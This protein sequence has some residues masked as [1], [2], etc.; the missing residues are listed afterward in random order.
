M[1]YFENEFKKLL[2]KLLDGELSDVIENNHQ[3]IKSISTSFNKVLGYN[4]EDDNW[5]MFEDDESKPLAPVPFTSFASKEQIDVL[6]FGLNPMYGK[7]VMEEKRVAGS[8]WKDY[9]RFYAADGGF[10]FF[11]DSDNSYYKNVMKMM[12]GLKSDTD[13][14]LDIGVASIRKAFKSNKMSAVEGNKASAEEIF[15]DHS[16]V[17]ADLMPFHSRATSFSYSDM[18]LLEESCPTYKNYLDEMK[19]FINKSMANEGLIIGYGSSTSKTIYNMYA[20]ERILDKVEAG[21]VN[22]Y[23]LEDKWLVLF[24]HQILGFNCAMPGTLQNELLTAIRKYIRGD[25]S[26]KTIVEKTC[27]A[28]YKGRNSS[29]KNEIKEPVIEKRVKKENVE[30]EYKELNE[31]VE[32][33]DI[34]EMFLKARPELMTYSTNQGSAFLGTDSFNKLPKRV[35]SR[36]E[37]PIISYELLAK[38]GKPIT[39]RLVAFEHDLDGF[40]PYKKVIEENAG[41]FYKFKNWDY[42]ETT[43]VT[44]KGLVQ[45]TLLRN[46]ERYTYEELERILTEQ[47]DMFF[48]HYA[49]KVDEIFR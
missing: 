25:K 21:L 28:Y 19:V 1:N 16:F 40:Q 15:S 10:D 27:D 37:F 23:Q 4:K 12:Y 49:E 36:Q 38:K 14:A 13:E 6:Y 7:D 31:N 9:T 11:F 33:R 47:L 46:P 30:V 18:L 39:I 29:R 41:T 5:L 48:D 2:E 20:S 42:K 43:K 32:I 22:I 24:G 45:R 17:L 3:K 8:N 35:K 34:V 26:Q 44:S